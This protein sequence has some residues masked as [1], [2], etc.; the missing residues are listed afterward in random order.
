MLAWARIAEVMSVP[1]GATNPTSGLVKPG[2]FP[3][4]FPATIAASVPV[5]TSWSPFENSGFS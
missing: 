5:P 2:R 3:T 1:S 4:S